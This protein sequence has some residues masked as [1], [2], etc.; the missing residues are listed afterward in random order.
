MKA[1]MRQMADDLRELRRLAERQAERS[2]FSRIL[3]GLRDR[4]V[5][6]DADIERAE[7]A[8]PEGGAL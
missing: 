7:R 4:G 2:D 5:I 3:R 1:M 8:G 6:T